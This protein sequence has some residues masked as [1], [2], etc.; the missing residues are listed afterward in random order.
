MTEI[1]FLEY[2]LRQWYLQL[3]ISFLYPTSFKKYFLKVLQFVSRVIS[4]F[5]QEI[6][7]LEY[8]LKHHLDYLKDIDLISL[9]FM[10]SHLWDSF[11]YTFHGLY[12]YLHSVYCLTV[13]YK[14]FS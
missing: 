1:D 4:K 8:K 13:D 11:A 5:L 14:D 2:R 12:F 10:W 6:D 9:L 3:Q 7:F